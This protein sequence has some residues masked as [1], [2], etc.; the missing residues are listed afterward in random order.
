MRFKKKR[1][2]DLVDLLSYCRVVIR[3]RANPCSRGF[4]VYHMHVKSPF[5]E[6]DC[7]YFAS[8]G[9]TDFSNLLAVPKNDLKRPRYLPDSRRWSQGR[10]RRRVRL[11]SQVRST[12]AIRRG[13]SRLRSPREVSGGEWT[14]SNSRH[15]SRY[16][17]FRAVRRE[18]V[19]RC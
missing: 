19:S 18:P 15:L 13:T 12:L 14:D 2:N 11:Y 4:S 1:K 9:R 6:A 16:L 3:P 8:C 7:F 10:R 17:A 5:T